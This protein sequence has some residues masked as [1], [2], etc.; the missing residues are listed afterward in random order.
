MTGP[1]TWTAENRKGP[2]GGTRWMR[3]S[4][5]DSVILTQGLLPGWPPSPS[6]AQLSTPPKPEAGAG[7]IGAPAGDPACSPPSLGESWMAQGLFPGQA[8]QG[9]QFLKPPACFSMEISHL[10]TGSG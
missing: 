9:L 1:K 10:K 6:P 3:G 2:W 7:L 8:K 4:L 5:E